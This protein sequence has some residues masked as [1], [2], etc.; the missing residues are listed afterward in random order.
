MEIVSGFLVG[1]MGS[2]H[3][4][5][6][7]GPIALALPTGG[8]TGWPRLAG[9]VAYNGGRILTY[10]FLGLLVGAAGQGIALLGYQ[11]AL[12][13]SLGAVLIVTSLAPAAVRR[14]LPRVPGGR[15]FQLMVSDRLGAL[16]RRRTVSSLF[17][18]RVLNGLV[19]G[20]FV[21]AG[22]AGAATTGTEAGGAMFMAGFGTGTV[23]VMLG[24]SMAGY[25][26]PAVFRARIVSLLPWFGV[27]LG[28]LLIVRG[29]GLGI[30]YLSPVPPSPDAPPGQLCH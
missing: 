8:K 6:M 17:L 23:P 3:C 30:P 29:L 19:P 9:R 27:L 28:V 5:G 16:L 7:C 11:Q 25:R 15:A 2:V 22:L 12:S 20:G 1:I 10:A 18:I 26:L 14:F 24:L 13:I 21:V 4:A